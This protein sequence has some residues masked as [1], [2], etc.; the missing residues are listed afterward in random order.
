MKMT[1]SYYGETYQFLKTLS[2]LDITKL[3]DQF[4][5]TI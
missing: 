2:I 1:G 5:N 4:M 3:D